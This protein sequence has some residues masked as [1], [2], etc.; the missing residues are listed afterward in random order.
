MV[1]ICVR[2]TLGPYVCCVLRKIKGLVLN[3]LTIWKR[4]NINGE[5][6]TEFSANG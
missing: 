4:Q 3:L 2:L 5:K 1:R 6:V